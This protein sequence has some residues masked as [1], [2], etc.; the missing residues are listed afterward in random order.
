MREPSQREG[1]DGYVWGFKDMADESR[2]EL[3]C[4]EDGANIFWLSFCPNGEIGLG[5]EGPT[6]L[7]EMTVS[8]FSFLQIGGAHEQVP[9]ECFD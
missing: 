5:S 1:G 4:V 3:V 7:G 6:D 2:D 8:Q 9:M